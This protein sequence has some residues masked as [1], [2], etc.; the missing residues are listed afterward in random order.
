MC[1]LCFGFDSKNFT[2]EENASD[3]PDF[4]NQ[5]KNMYYIYLFIAWLC[6]GSYM[7]LV[8]KTA[9]KERSV[10]TCLL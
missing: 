6:F 8:D 2:I 4:R 7:M 5:R 3:Y 10:F 9:S 1:Q